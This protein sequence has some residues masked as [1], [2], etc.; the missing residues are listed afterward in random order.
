MRWMITHMSNLLPV[1]K[2]RETKSLVVFHHPQPVHALHVLLVP[3]RP[4][5]NLM[6]VSGEDTDFLAD[7]I[8]MV[9]ELVGEYGLEQCGYRLIVNGGTY[10][11][12][13]HLHFHLVSDGWKEQK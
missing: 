2:I 10:Q 12:V 9:Q 1:N 6:E 7:L 11:D 5:A 8:H 13:P 4:Y 3:K